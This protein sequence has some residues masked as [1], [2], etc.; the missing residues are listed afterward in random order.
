MG[1]LYHQGHL[2]VAA[3][4]VH[5]HCKGRPPTLGNLSE[6]LNIVT[7]EIS[8]ISRELEKKKIIGVVKSG[9]EES[10]HVLDHLRL[11]DLPREEAGANALQE[12]LS[13]FRRQQDAR[14]KELEST[15]ESDRSRSDVFQGLDEALKN[16]AAG[17]KRKNPLD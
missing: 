5:E 11:E 3:I 6:M 12:E 8:R 9:G 2:F 13:S 10:F 17:K 14:M 7:D 4:R 1:N 15:L 16:P